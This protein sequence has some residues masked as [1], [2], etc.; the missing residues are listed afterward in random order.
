[1][2]NYTNVQCNKHSLPKQGMLGYNDI[3]ITVYFSQ[4]LTSM[5]ES[6]L[7]SFTLLPALMASGIFSTVANMIS[8][9]TAVRT[10]PSICPI[11]GQKNPP[12]MRAILRM[13]EV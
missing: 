7:V 11:G 9:P 5:D 10:L 1:M 12:M 8:N 6:P 3:E 4:E 13:N 2:S